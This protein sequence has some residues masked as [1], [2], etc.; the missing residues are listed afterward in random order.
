MENTPTNPLNTG[1]GVPGT[2]PVP[3]TPVSAVSATP[4]TPVN[5]TPGVAKPATATNVTPVNTPTQSPLEK[6]MAMKKYI[7]AG[8]GVIALLVS[9]YM[10]YSYFTGIS[11]AIDIVKDEAQ[12]LQDLSNKL[13][14]PSNN[15][16][17]DNDTVDQLKSQINNDTPP[18]DSAPST[19]PGI[20]IGAEQTTTTPA[21]TKDSSETTST[22]SVPR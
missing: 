12:G 2:T 3:V 8:V 9:I 5:I 4:S 13:G 22:E 18:K 1:N 16:T 7:I 10:A 14:S 17:P 15:T 19:P 20:T 21:T 6:I 11:S